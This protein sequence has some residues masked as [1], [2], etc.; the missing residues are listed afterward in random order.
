MKAFKNH[1]KSSS[2]PI[3]RVYYGPEDESVGNAN[4]KKGNSARLHFD[5]E[6]EA[7]W[8]GRLPAVRLSTRIAA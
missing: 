4:T 5:A 1:K 8:S 7:F 2:Q 6:A 3:L